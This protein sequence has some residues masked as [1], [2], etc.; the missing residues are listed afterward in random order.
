MRSLLLS[1]LVSAYS[2]HL[3]GL[4]ANIREGSFNGPRGPH[5]RWHIPAQ[6]G[7]SLGSLHTIR[8]KLQIGLTDESSVIYVSR[9]QLAESGPIVAQITARSVDANLLGLRVTMH[10]DLSPFCNQSTDPFCD[11]GR[12]NTYDVEV[13]DR[14]GADSFQ[15]DHGVMISKTKYNDSEVPFQWTIDA[16]PQ[17]INLTDFY[18]P[19][20]TPSYVTIG[21]Y[22]QLA[23]ALFHAG[24]RSGSEFEYVDEAN[25]LHFYV[26]DIY[27]D[28]DGVLSYTVGVRSLDD[29][30]ANEYGVEVDIGQACWSGRSLTCSFQLTN[31]GSRG[32]SAADDELAQYRISDIYRLQAEVKGEGWHAQLQNVLAAIDIGES[33]TVEVALDAERHAT[34]AATVVLRVTSESDPSVSVTRECVVS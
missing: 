29:E 17:D 31:T 32:S 9:K 2:S 15:P 27:R 20:G 19:D 24:T 23:D 10:E 12:Y 8:D 22:R 30:S 14:M 28:V 16:N 25:R 13:I 21:D 3:T 18:R 4:N 26:I 7:G 1:I 33:A 11:G 5:T 6:H 34:R